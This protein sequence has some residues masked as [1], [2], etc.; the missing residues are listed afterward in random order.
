[1]DFGV[2]LK[3]LKPLFREKGR[4]KNFEEE[5]TIF[6]KDDPGDRLYLI[7]EGIVKII[8][9]SED[10]RELVLAIMHKDDI[11]GEMS[12]IDQKPRSACAI[13]VTKTKLCELDGKVFMNF[14]KGNPEI[15]VNII[16]VLSERLRDTNNF[17]EDTVFLNLSHRILNR[18]RKI[19]EHCGVNRGDYIEI[20][21]GFSQKEL[22]ALVGCSRE[23]LN[24]ELKVLKDAGVIDYDKHSI[25]IF[26]VLNKK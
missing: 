18:L 6:Y 7:E 13:T 10:G 20:P 17:A 21:H 14:L 15:L 22:S 19:S 5:E 24:K 12:V 11:F 25:K 1:M 9:F 2:F 8:N 23:N 3:D 26:N 16:K 4:L